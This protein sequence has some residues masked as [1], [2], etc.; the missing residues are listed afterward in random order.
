LN[1]PAPPPLAPTTIS[2]KEQAAFMDKSARAAWTYVNKEITSAGFVGATRNYQ[3]LTVWDMASTLASAYSARELGYIGDDAYKTFVNR[4]L[5]SMEKLALY[6]NAAF[7][8]MYSATTGAMV[9]NNAKVSKVGGGWS[10]LDHGRLLVWLKIIGNSDPQF[11]QRTQALINRLDMSR[12][13]RDGYMQGEE[14]TKTGQHRAYQ[15]GRVGYEQYAAEGFALWGAKVDQ[16]IDFAVNAKPVVVNGAT[17]VTD[18]RGGDVMTSEPFVMMGLELGWKNA[19]WKNLGLAVLAAQE[20]RFRQTGI[21]TM[22]S[23]DAIPVPPAYFYYYL[24]Y[25]DGKPFVVSTVG[26][27]VSDEYPRWVSAKAAFGYHALV[28][29]D[30]T[31]RALQTVK[32]GSGADGWTAGVFEGTK[33]AT[34]TYNLNTAAIVMESAAYMKRGSCPL[35]QARCAQ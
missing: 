10:A 3:Y 17:I 1:I 12:I 22:V 24:L 16:A 32:Y 20:A 8:R 14:I 23:E 11:G 25:R 27:A 2:A 29:S 5:T 26:G 15:E 28:P 31:W 18:T 33:N 6:D 4:T 13:V 19:T 30:Y 9:D 35:I 21:V 34:R 7:N